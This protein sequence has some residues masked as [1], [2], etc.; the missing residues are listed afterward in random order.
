[1]WQKASVAIEMIEIMNWMITQKE[2]N[3]R[4]VPGR[5]R[6]RMVT[7]RTECDWDTDAGTERFKLDTGS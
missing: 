6:I 1:M 4:R 2:E 7:G 5:W 3:Q